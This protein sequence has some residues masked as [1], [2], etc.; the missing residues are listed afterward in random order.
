MLRTTKVF[1]EETL[2]VG[3]AVGL[4]LVAM[5][6]AWTDLSAVSDIPELRPETRSEGEA[7]IA[8]AP[9]DCSLF[10]S[11]PAGI[12]S[13][14][15][16]FDIPLVP[17]VRPVVVASST[18]ASV[19]QTV[20]SIAA[21]ITTAIATRSTIA[22]SA[23]LIAS[24]PIKLVASA[25]PKLPPV[26]AVVKLPP[27][28][29]VT[30]KPVAPPPAPPPPPDLFALGYRLKGIIRR[31]SGRSAAFIFDPSRGRDV[32]VV[33]GASDPIRLTDVKER[34]VELLTPS[35]PGFL[36]LQGVVASA[37]KLVV[38]L[39]GSDGKTVQQ[40]VAAAVLPT[41][42]NASN[43]AAASGPASG[44]VSVSSPAPSFKSELPE[45]MKKGM[46]QIAQEEGRW[47]MVVRSLSPET[48][49]AQFG[50]REGDRIMGVNGKSFPDPMVIKAMLEA[51]DVKSGEFTVLRLGQQIN[52][53]PMPP[54]SPGGV[55]GQS[56]GKTPDGISPSGLPQPPRHFLAPGQPVPPGYS[57]PPEALMPPGQPMRSLPMP[58]A[59][60][61]PNPGGPPQYGGYPPPPP[62]PANSNPPGMPP[63][64]PP[65]N[66]S[67][68][69]PSM[70]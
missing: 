50:A 44:P 11:E 56:P 62:P 64:M 26:K 53:R 36:A 46:L 43:S 59:T 48:I 47:V 63:G 49:L 13:F 30:V 60:V 66:P 29:S 9:L 15:R 5:L 32:V 65:E 57:M 7:A 41:S 12:A 40:V 4:F 18:L 8:S 14:A 25:S 42:A 22:S 67:G 38:V 20:A 21:A 17:P 31:K 70:F 28:A 27:P 34:R 52:L 24:T 61:N 37:S 33:M 35:G 19:S 58:P 68:A 69:P 55:S 39:P 2:I 45:L 16:L 3:A 54:I 51:T 23:A 6:W 1:P 10:L